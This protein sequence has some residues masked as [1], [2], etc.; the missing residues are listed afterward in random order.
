MPKRVKRK[1]NKP[2]VLSEEFE[3]RIRR[4]DAL[5][6]FITDPPSEWTDENSAESSGG[7]KPSLE[8][9]PCES[10]E[11]LLD[12][13][14][15]AMKWTDGLD[16]GLSVMLASVTSTMALGDQLWVK[17]LAPASSGKSVLCEAISS[18]TKYILA[19]S[20]IR[21]FHSGF[22]DGD[23]DHS[24]ISKLNGKTLVTKD[25]DT[26]LQSPNLGQVLSEARDVYDT[27][28][29]TSYR[30]K[31]SRD[32]S[33]VRMTWILCGTS[34]LR[35]IDSS[36]LGERF[37]DCVMMDG[38]CDDLEDEVL[39]RVA[40][41]ARASL[42]L[43]A[44]EN[45][46]SQEDPDMIKAKALTGGYINYLR[47]N[48]M[49]LLNDCKF[50]DENLRICTRF[51]KF[52]AYMRARPSKMQDETAEREFGA[53][54]ASQII[55]LA[56]CLAVVFN[57][58]EVNKRVIDKAR[59][60]AMDTARG[61]VL[62]ITRIMFDAGEEGIEPSVLAKLTNQRDSEVRVLLRFL[63]RIKVV[64]VFEFK[65]VSRL[66]KQKIKKVRWRLSNTVTNLYREVME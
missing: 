32:Y 31:N 18:N 62:D 5:W 54:L 22:G 7:S 19:K 64:E 58:P 44:G 56:N 37:L 25:G 4:L 57:E 28:S 8:L 11:V 45:L 13:W 26:L 65:K 29:R 66:S 50:S 33:G 48:S 14:K 12:S 40:R 34:S 3:S 51:G 42:C 20:T 52:V 17:I 27:V 36:E 16:H 6:Q 61:P 53:R 21:G 24:L 15:E 9:A 46:E 30:N 35:S 10:Y 43:E 1:R 55:R 23:E 49:N 38:I 39:M 41:K 60:V 59:R 63:K 47:Q 2:E